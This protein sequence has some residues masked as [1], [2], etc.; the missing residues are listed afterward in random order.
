[1]KNGEPRACPDC[2][3]SR[4]VLTQRGLAGPTDETDQHFR[5]EQ[6]G[7]VTYEII[8][9]SARDIRL[10]QIRPGSVIR[11]GGHNYRVTRVLKIGLD[12]FLVYLRADNDAR[13]TDH[14][15]R[16]RR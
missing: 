16:S 14:H 13:V 10:E 6:C 3:S 2:G 15:R 1:V 4:I 12:E 9:R 7:R 8:S 11:T 5:C